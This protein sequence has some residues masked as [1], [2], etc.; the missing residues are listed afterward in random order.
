MTNWITSER[1][2]LNVKQK[3]VRIDKR[4]QGNQTAH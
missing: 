4:V 2:L 1:R 3:V